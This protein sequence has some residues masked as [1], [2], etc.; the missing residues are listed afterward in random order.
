MPRCSTIV[1][2]D[3]ARLKQLDSLDPI[4]I[5][6]RVRIDFVRELRTFAGKHVQTTL[7][8]ISVQTLPTHK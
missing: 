6:Q 2:L 3:P 8:D 7:I 1:V 5:A 4:A